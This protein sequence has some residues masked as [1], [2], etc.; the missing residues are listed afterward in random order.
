MT[1]Q[2]TT[3]SNKTIKTINDALAKWD[4]EKSV[5]SYLKE[6]L[7]E[8]NKETGKKHI[9]EIVDNA[10]TRAKDEEDPKWTPLIIG[11]A[12]PRQNINQTNLQINNNIISEGRQR[13]DDGMKAILEIKE[14]SGK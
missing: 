11:M 2:P 5:S 10:I 4:L 6:K 1:K 3:N 7:G 12:E 8:E 14:E 9:D 13:L